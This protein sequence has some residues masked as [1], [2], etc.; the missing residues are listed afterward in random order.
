MY[1][2][3]G[4]GRQ[5]TGDTILMTTEMPFLFA[6]MLQVSKMIYSKSDFI[7]IFNDFIHVYSPGPRAENSFGTNV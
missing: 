3:S 4:R 7:Y 6:H 1:I 2:A 5:S